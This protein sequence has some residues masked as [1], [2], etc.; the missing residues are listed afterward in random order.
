MQPGEELIPVHIPILFCDGETN[1]LVS[2]L[3]TFM[4]TLLISVVNG[5]RQVGVSFGVL[6]EDGEFV[7]VFMVDE[8]AATLIGEAVAAALAAGK[9][10]ETPYAPLG[11]PGNDQ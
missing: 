1:R 9:D 11:P 3:A 4:P 5:E 2:M 7:S 10:P 6:Q 8:R